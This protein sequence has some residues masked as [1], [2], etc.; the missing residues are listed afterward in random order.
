MRI[1]AARA[2]G[3]AALLLFI[4]IGVHLAPLRPSLLCLQL[5]F[6]Q[7]AFE[8]VLEQWQP[9]GVALYRSHLPADFVLLGLYGAF[10]YVY[11]SRITASH[12]IGRLTAAAL[13]AALPVAAV[14]DAIENGLHLMLTWRPA[15]AAPVLY[16][17]SGLAAS[18]KWLAFAVFAASAVAAWRSA[19]RDRPG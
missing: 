5:S 13:V 18:L 1:H 3:L 11:G 9:R 16:A 2:L 15:A 19:P 7:A 12:A 8:G 6:T 14:A 4:A 10:G 17:V